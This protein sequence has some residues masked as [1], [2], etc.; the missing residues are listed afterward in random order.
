MEACLVNLG[1]YSLEG[2]HKLH[3]HHHVSAVY[4]DHFHL[5]L[6]QLWNADEA[7][8]IQWMENTY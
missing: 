3:H 7:V 6:Q 4:P 2:N 5:N 8:E 1:L